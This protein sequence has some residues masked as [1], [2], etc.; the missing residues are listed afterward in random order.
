MS[1]SSE[2][3]T[4]ELEE[5]PK[6]KWHKIFHVPFIGD[7]LALCVAGFPPLFA[8]MFVNHFFYNGEDVT[9]G[10]YFTFA[11][12]MVIWNLFLWIFFD[13]LLTIPIIP[14]PWFVVAFIHLLYQT[15]IIIWSFFKN[16]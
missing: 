11:L 10:T 7:T 15:G 2:P 9:S 6:P 14:I 13:L 16:L 12:F 8:Q 3:N 4:D 1:E 5:K